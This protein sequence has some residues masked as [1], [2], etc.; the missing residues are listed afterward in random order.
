MFYAANC[1]TL[2]KLVNA[3]C[4]IGSQS[5]IGHVGVPVPYHKYVFNN[6]T[7]TNW[8]FKNSQIRPPS[9][10]NGTVEH[11]TTPYSGDSDVVTLIRSRSKQHATAESYTLCI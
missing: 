6:F 3:K 1:D 5:T 2:L 4:K 7:L 11:T 10:F 9:T 8:L